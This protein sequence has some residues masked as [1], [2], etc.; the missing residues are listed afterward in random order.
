MP[1]ALRHHMRTSLSTI[2]AGLLTSILLLGCGDADTSTSDGAQGPASVS[3]NGSGGGGSGGD[4]SG[5]NGSTSSGGAG[6]GVGGQGVGGAGSGG[7]SAAG[8][9]GDGGDGQGGILSGTGWVEISGSDADQV[10]RPASEYPDYNGS[11]SSQYDSIQGSSNAQGFA[12]IMSNWSGGSYCPTRNSVL[13]FGGGHGAYRGN[14]VLEFD[15]DSQSWARLTDPTIFPMSNVAG[16][17][18]NTP[19][20]RHTYNGVTWDSTRNVMLVNDGATAD[21]GFCKGDLWKFDPST[22][23]WTRL[24]DSP[25]GGPNINFIYVP[26]VDRAYR[27]QDTTPQGVWEYNPVND[28]WSKVNGTGPGNQQGSV[29]YNPGDDRIW[30][31]DNQ[32]V[33]RI[34]NFYNHSWSTQ[35]TSGNAPPADSFPGLSW[36]VTADA[37]A[38]WHGGASVY[39]LDRNF[40]WSKTTLGGS[41]PPHDPSGTAGDPYGKFQYLPTLNAYYAVLTTSDNVR[42]GFI[43]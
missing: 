37:A 4:N 41:P 36:N 38:W 16:Q 25:A 6:Q 43:D 32:G 1:L 22:A 35:P 11:S 42:V 17:A 18:D 12:A 5:G 19:T 24:A 40:V 15:L 34:Y 20:S 33:L 14:E 23:Q 27:F 30:H 28:S 9:S 29:V 26:S 13:H 3:S 8:G 39:L 31:Y 21:L 2:S 10:E 7:G